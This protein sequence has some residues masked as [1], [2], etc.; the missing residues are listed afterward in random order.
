MYPRVGRQTLCPYYLMVREMCLGRG[1]RRE[2]IEIEHC[3]QS[4]EIIHL[5]AY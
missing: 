5:P 2:E 4:L 3:A 1:K